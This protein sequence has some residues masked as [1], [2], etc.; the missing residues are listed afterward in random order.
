MGSAATPVDSGSH[1]S[2]CRQP[3]ARGKKRKKGEKR[4]QK[5][6]KLPKEEEEESQE[7]REMLSATVGLYVQGCWVKKNVT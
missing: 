5:R 7:K 1:H 4:G 6:M 2:H 3:A